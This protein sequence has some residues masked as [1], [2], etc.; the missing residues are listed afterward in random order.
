MQF[1]NKIKTIKL[2]INT[3]WVPRAA[4]M[5]CE[6]TYAFPSIH[7][8]WCSHS[9]QGIKHTELKSFLI[10]TFKCTLFPPNGAEMQYD[11][12]EISRPEVVI[13]V[14]CPYSKTR[15]KEMKGEQGTD[16]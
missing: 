11:K 7:F 4:C 10:I 12:I 1:K 2:K 8:I 3:S 14:Q 9:L 15:T 13:L 6:L 16:H 5:S